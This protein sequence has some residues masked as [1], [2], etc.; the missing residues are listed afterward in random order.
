MTNFFGVLV[1]YCIELLMV[2]QPLVT[3]KSA[4]HGTFIF[5]NADDS[6][7]LY[8][9]MSGLILTCYIQLKKKKGRFPWKFPNSLSV[10]SH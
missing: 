4:Q 3:P 10:S 9:V 6:M 1:F 7:Y 8:Q 5:S 2:A